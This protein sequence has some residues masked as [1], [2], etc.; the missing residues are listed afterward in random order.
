MK[1][2]LG[3]FTII[4]SFYGSAYAQDT[5]TITNPEEFQFTHCYPV[6]RSTKPVTHYIFDVRDEKNHKVY[7]KQAVASTKAR[8]LGELTK[9]DENLEANGNPNFDVT[10]VSKKLDLQFLLTI[11]DDGGYSMTGQ[12][13]H[14]G[15]SHAIKCLEVEYS[16]SGGK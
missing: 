4:I 9:L 7:T 11:Q 3:I 15:E 12:L 13:L 16:W 5:L 10:W 1:S 6:T 14:K 2:I 8:E